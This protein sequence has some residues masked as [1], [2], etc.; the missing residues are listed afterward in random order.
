MLGLVWWVDGWKGEG[1]RGLIRV[2][3]VEIAVRSKKTKK[4]KKQTYKYIYIVP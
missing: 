2:A 1:E 4:Q 3:I